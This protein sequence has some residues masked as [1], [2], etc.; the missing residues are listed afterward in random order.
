LEKQLQGCTIRA[1]QDGMVVWANDMSGGGRRGEQGPKIDLGA[2]VQ[3]NQVI[4]KLPDLKHMQVKT[5][6]HET[7]VDQLRPGM[8]ARVKIQDREFQGEIG[9]IANQP[10]PGNWF[11]TSVKEYA[12]IVKI[13]GEPEGLKPGMTAEVAFPLNNGIIVSSNPGSRTH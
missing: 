8:R 2:S 5:L 1:P 11:S 4:F 6:V 9:S 7:K 10:E 3:Q 13:D 12:T